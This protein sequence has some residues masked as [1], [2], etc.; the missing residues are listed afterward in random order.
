M[1]K[2]LAELIEKKYPSLKPAMLTRVAL[3]E[4]PILFIGT[5]TP[6]NTSNSERK[7][8]NAFRVWLTLID[9]RTGRIVAKSLDKA[10]AASVDAVPLSFYRDSPTWPKDRTVT[11]YIE[12]CKFGSKVGD[13]ADPHYISKL[14]A[15]AAINEALLSYAS[16]Q[17]EDS[18]RLFHEAAALADGD[19]LRIEN[20]LYL[21]SWNLGRTEE[22]RGA[23][24]Q[25]VASGLKAHHLN[26]K[27][28]FTP[29]QTTLLE[30]GDL[31]A[32]YGMWLRELAQLTAHEGAC[33]N[34][35]GHTSKTGTAAVNDPL[36]FAR[37]SR[38]RELLATGVPGLSNRLTAMGRGSRENLIGLGTDDLRDAL[39]RR[40]ELIVRNC[41]A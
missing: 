1:G 33:L 12:S 21:T 8:A 4:D 5:L 38:V 28:L 39:D 10:T 27:F 13:P 15:A 17:M 31:S 35:V 36:S 34:V 26:M 24:D 7:P 11:A 14:P 40:V 25:I 6:Y 20:G 16:G 3:A 29:S 37:A 41:S 19:D 32:Q 9:L 18:N 22:A 30:E 23:F 2:I